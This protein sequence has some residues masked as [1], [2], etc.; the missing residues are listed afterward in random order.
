MSSI[1]EPADA[2]IRAR[3]KALEDHADIAAAAAKRAKSADSRLAHAEIE[4]TLRDR[5]NELLRSEEAA[6]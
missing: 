4:K 2:L 6:A 3:L 5:I 1:A